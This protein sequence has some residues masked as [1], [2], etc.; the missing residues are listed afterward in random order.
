MI[1]LLDLRVFL[2]SVLGLIHR[3]CSQ[4]FLKYSGDTQRGWVMSNACFISHD[5]VLKRFFN[6][7]HETIQMCSLY[8]IHHGKFLLVM[9]APRHLYKHNVK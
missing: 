6:F 2:Q 1:Y 7:E 4:W 3:L 9:K 8:M 5:L